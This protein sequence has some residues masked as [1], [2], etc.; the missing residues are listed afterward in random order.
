MGRKAASCAPRFQQTLDSHRT[1]QSGKQ[2]TGGPTARIITVWEPHNRQRSG[3][4]RIESCLAF[5]T[6][7]TRLIQISPTRNIGPLWR[8]KVSLGVRAPTSRTGLL[9]KGRLLEINSIRTHVTHNLTHAEKPYISRCP[10][11]LSL[12]F[13]RCPDWRFQCQLLHQG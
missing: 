8:M 5:L 9:G 1:A 4:N 11:D 2:L 12:F 7:K 6:A 13:R 10:S 3:E